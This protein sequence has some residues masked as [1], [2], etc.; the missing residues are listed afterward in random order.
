M[1]DIAGKW[2]GTIHGANDGSVF[3]ESIVD[4]GRLIGSA[5]IR[6]MSLCLESECIPPQ[7]RTKLWSVC[8][9]CY[10]QTIEHISKCTGLWKFL[11]VGLRQEKS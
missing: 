11:L 3:V 6:S 5:Q 1:Q 7:V 8:A 9:W 10:H 4:G 2:V